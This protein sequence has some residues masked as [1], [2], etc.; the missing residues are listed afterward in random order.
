[1]AKPKSPLLS[2]GARGTIADTL[3]FQKRGRAHFARE[4]PIPKD[5]KSPAQLIWRQ[6]YKDAVAAWHALSQEEKEAWRGVCPGLT[7]YQCFMR[8]ELKYPLPPLPIDI[9][10]PAEDRRYALNVYTVTYLNLEN[11]ANESGFLHTVEVWFN[12]NAT[13]VVVGTLYNTTGTNYKC[14]DVAA[15]GAVA[16]GAKGTFP[17]LNIAVVAGDLIGIMSDIGDIDRDITG[18]AGLR[19]TDGK[20]IVVGDEQTYTF[21]ANQGMSLYGIGATP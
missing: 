18:F 3:T 12:S 6:I 9:G 21:V 7:A 10:I 4:K 15:I 5:P 14:R 11:P 1:M 2:L 17:G 16:S 20:H 8:S 13:G 19:R